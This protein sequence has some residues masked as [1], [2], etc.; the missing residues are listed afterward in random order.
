MPMSMQA[1]DAFRPDCRRVEHVTRA[2]ASK[3]EGPG[4]TTGDEQEE[5][6]FMGLDFGTSGARAMV[7]DGR[8]SIQ[9]NAKRSYP[10][11]LFKC[12]CL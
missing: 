4:K 8:G 3:K 5:P 1:R 9:A 10:V 7:I 12:T 11:R 6:L 2:G